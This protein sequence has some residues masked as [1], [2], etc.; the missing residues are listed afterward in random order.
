MIIG[1]INAANEKNAVLPIIGK[2]FEGKF[3]FISQK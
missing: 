2:L 3:S 1:I